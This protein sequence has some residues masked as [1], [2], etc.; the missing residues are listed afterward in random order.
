MSQEK[1]AK[2]QTSAHPDSLKGAEKSDIELKETEL[3]KVTGGASF[4]EI[5][6]TKT[7]DKGSST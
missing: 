6:I 4:S 7:Y 3:N 2:P 1:P 5:T